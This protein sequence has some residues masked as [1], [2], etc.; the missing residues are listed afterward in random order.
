MRLTH[1]ACVLFV[2]APQSYDHD[3]G[4]ESEVIDTFHERVGIDT[5]RALVL[6]AHTRPRDSSE[7]VFVVR[8]H[9]ITLEAQNA[10]LKLLE[11]PPSSARVLFVL[12]R[13]FQLLATLASRV[14]II[15]GTDTKEEEDVF[16]AFLKLSV[17]ERITEIEHA[18]KKKDIEWQRG[19]KS[20]LIQYVE[21]NRTNSAYRELEFV[22]RTVL[23][24]GASNKMLF[25]H[26]AL[27]L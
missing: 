3:L 25:E 6:Q 2:R 12:P 24:R 9:F 19:M 22:A 11:E 20:G 7:Q 16:A 15:K 27:L 17:K 13:D 18:M 26:A 14:E 5:A 23:T 1:H 21:Q 8:T 4:V 10:L